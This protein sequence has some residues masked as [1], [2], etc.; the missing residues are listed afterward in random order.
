MDQE[1]KAKWVDA[2]RSGEY[3]Q[4]KERL[5]NLGDNSYCCLGVLADVAGAWS[6]QAKTRVDGYGAHFTELT[7]DKLGLPYSID[8]PEVL[9]DDMLMLMNDSGDCTFA[10]IADKIER[11]L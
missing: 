7:A 9:D 2:L 5:H 8:D 1:L 4:G 6:D 3:K 11:E 10:E